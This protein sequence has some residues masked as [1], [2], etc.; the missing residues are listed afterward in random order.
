[1]AREFNIKTSLNQ[2]SELEQIF[3]QLKFPQWLKWKNRNTLNGGEYSGIYMLGH[4]ID[5][6]S[7]YADPLSRRDKAIVRMVSE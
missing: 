5:V 3:S 7:G 1:M 6:P 4:F 2:N